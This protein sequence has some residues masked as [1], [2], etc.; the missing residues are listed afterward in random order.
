MVAG[1]VLAAVVL[2]SS[3]ALVGAGWAPLVHWS[4]E[5][6]GIVA[7]GSE[8]MVPAVLVNSPYLGSAFGLAVA[9][10]SFP[11]MQGFGPPGSSVGLGV[12]ASLGG[13]GGAFFLVNVSVYHVADALAVGPGTNARCDGPLRAVL[14]SAP[15]TA[16]YGTPVPVPSNESDVHEAAFL[17]HPMHPSGGTVVAFFNNSFWTANRPSV[18]TCGDTSGITTSTVGTG[19]TLGFNATWQGTN[20]VVPYHFPFALNFT[21]HFPANAGIWQV[22]DLGAPGGPGGGWAFQYQPC[23]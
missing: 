18:S 7:V 13:A 22:D 16:L 4:C 3:L 14:S 19:L 15:R 23:P 2:F 8:V 1:V 12:N 17:A 20:Y 5:A 9:P 6:Q 10:E 11:G 21:Y